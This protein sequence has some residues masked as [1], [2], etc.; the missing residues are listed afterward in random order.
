MGTTYSYAPFGGRR[1]VVSPRAEG[2]TSHLFAFRSTFKSSKMDRIDL[3][4][5]N[6]ILFNIIDL[7]AEIVNI[8]FC[9]PD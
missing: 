5:L 1:K 3:F 2:G 4:F 8:S 7:I 6:K 9:L